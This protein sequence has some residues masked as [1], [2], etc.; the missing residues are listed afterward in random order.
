MKNRVHIIG[1]GINGLCTAWYLIE[2]GYEVM[3][4]DRSELLDGTS[5]GNAGMIVPSH[6]VP[7]ASPGVMAKGIKWMFSSKS[8]FYIKPRLDLDLLFWTWKFYRSSTPEHVQNSCNV[9]F[10]FNQWSKQLYRSFSEHAGFSFGYQEKGLL[11]LYR[12]TKQEKEEL[13]FAEM[14]KELGIAVNQYNSSDLN[15]IEDVTV[16]ALG[17]ILFPGDAHINPNLFMKDMIRDLKQKGVG[18]VTG[19]ELISINASGKKVASIKTTSHDIPVETLVITGGAWTSDLLKI[20]DL[21]LLLQPGKGYSITYADQ[22]Y[23]PK[24]PTILTEGKV[25]VTPLGEDLRIGGTLELGSRDKNINDRR[26]QGIKENVKLYYPDI[27]LPAVDKNIWIGY[28]PCSP[29]GLPYIGQVSPY[30]NL[31]VGTGHGMMGMSMGPATGKLLSQ[32]IRNEKRDLK[33][34]QAFSASR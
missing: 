20:L 18:F 19:E 12:S 17:G 28:R 7:L 11:M 32:I 16:D 10:E 23:M 6:F 26:L 27:D 31:F 14:A 34:E 1:G 13:E 3:I 4:I 2:S 22:K 8:P 33:F 21:K 25:A 9:L 29:D 30:K 5:F 15:D 24:Y